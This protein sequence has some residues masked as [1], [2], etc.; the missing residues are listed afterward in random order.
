MTKDDGGSAFPFFC[1]ATMNSPEYGMTLRDYFAAQAMVA[2]TPI[3]WEVQD[4]YID[5]PSLIA[6]QAETA[7]EMADALLEARKK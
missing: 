5:G 7:Y 1:E 3:Y 2:L 6:C 4:T